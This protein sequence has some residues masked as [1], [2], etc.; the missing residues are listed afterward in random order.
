MILSIKKNH[1][2]IQI[3]CH[4]IQN[5]VVSDKQTSKLEVVLYL[6]V[7]SLAMKYS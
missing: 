4:E 7:K 5:L 1:H 3:Q 2:N 6:K